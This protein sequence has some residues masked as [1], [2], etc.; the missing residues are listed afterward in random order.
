M[1]IFT[2]FSRALRDLAHPR[3]LAVLLL[4][5]LGAI[6]LWS[7]LA[8][9][10]WDTWSG[11]LRGAIDGT[12]AGA[13]LVAHSAAW[14]VGSLSAVLVFALLLPAMFITAVLITELVAMP[15]IV[16]VVERRYPG[17]VRRGG[18]AVMGSIANAAVAVL[19]FAVLWI[20]TLPLWLTGV[21]AAVLPALNSAYLNQRLF[22][23]DA[24]SEHA[25]RDEY[26]EI[27]DR[28]KGRLYGL[29]LL[30]ALLYYIPFVNLVAPVVSGLA[31][32]HF[33][34]GELARLRSLPAR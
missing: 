20:V 26:R 8:W 18:G 2:A 13:W 10:F 17:V 32:T 28:A 19:V 4:P 15:M 25:T 30:L 34:L 14:L 12:A 31:F 7:V 16:S 11:A 1:P 3:V 5:M 23:Y 27:V 6:V 9:F 33:G 21:G 29:G 22:R 24:L